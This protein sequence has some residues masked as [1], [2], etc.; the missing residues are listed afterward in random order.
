MPLATGE[1]KS[2]NGIK[3]V[4]SK[5]SPY[6]VEQMGF[7]IISLANNHMLDYGANGLLE[8]KKA[9]KKSTTLGAG[10]WNEAYQVKYIDI[11]GVRIGFFSGTSCDFASLKDNWTDK[12]KIGC[13]WINQ[14]EVNKILSTAKE[15]CDYLIVISHGGIE[16]M[17]VPL[18]EWRDRYRE[19][20]E[21]GADAIIASHPHVPQGIEEYKGKSIFYSL[22]NFFFDN[23][24]HQKPSFWD[25][26]ILAVLEIE[27]GKISWQSIPVIKK[28]DFLDIDNSDKIS[29]HLKYLKDILTDDEKYIEKVNSEVLRLYEKYKNWLLSGSNAIE[30]KLSIK[31][32]IQ[33]VKT[34]F[35]IKRNEKVTLHQIREES[36]RWLLARA[37]KLKSKT[38]L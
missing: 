11:K 10:N 22:G 36:T 2:P 23:D 5:A 35:F 14:S 32:L 13:A 3:L 18:P 16:H 27:N 25:N 6:C 8:T 33:M 30:L 28:N 12:Q 21:M 34:I 29:E 9:F 15:M 4:Q 38:E 31:S 26:G 37:L 20:I 19:L 17:E 7:N 1:L 24:N